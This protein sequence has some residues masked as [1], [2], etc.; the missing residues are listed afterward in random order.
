MISVDDVFGP[1]GLTGRERNEV[2]KA[3]KGGVLPSR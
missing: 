3:M 1:G 2:N